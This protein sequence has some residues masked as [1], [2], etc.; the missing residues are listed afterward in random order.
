MS[1]GSRAQGG[2]CRAVLIQVMAINCVHF[3]TLAKH[4]SVSGEECSALLSV[5]IKEFVKELESRVQGWKKKKKKKKKEFMFVTSFSVDINILPENFQMECIKLQSDIQLKNLIMFL[6]QTFLRPLLPEKNIL[7]FI[8]IPYSCHHF[9]AESTL[10][11]NC[12]G[13]GTGRVKFHQISSKFVPDVHLER[14]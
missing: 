4:S 5:L 10:V 11:N 1:I 3:N 13:W 12:P 8:T 7:R 2:Q 9:L 14:S 6:Y